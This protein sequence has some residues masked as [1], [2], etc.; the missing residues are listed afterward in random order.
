MP[1]NRYFRTARA[2]IS[3]PQQTALNRFKSCF[4]RWN[5][6]HRPDAVRTPAALRVN[7]RRHS[8]RRSARR[9]PTTSKVL[10][11]TEI[12]AERERER[13]LAHRQFVWFSVNSGEISENSISQAKSLASVRRV[14]NLCAS[15]G[16]T[17]LQPSAR[18]V[19]EALSVHCVSS[20]NSNCLCCLFT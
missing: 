5:Q 20:E 6:A 12:P 14:L 10:S 15:N 8:G 2:I 13:E 4:I 16:L 18:E 11:R 19:S 3:Q 17:A 9:I 7:R 1:S